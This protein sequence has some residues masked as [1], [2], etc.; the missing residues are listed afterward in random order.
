MGVR[1]RRRSGAA[2]L[3]ALATLCAILFLTFLD[4]T[5]VSVTLANIQT[6]L[7]SGITQ[8][9]WIVDGY[10]L[11][12]AGLMLAGGTLG[13][14]FGRKKVMLAGVALF[15]GGWRVRARPA[16]RPPGRPS[17]GRR[18]GSGRSSAACW[19]PASAGAAS[20]GSTWASARWHSSPRG[21]RFLRTPIRRGDVWTFQDSRSAPRQ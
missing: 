11:A 3:P 19:S 8:L 7:H 17:R 13:D 6:S 14:L 18:W 4:N 10:L 15:C 9:Q 20:S 16:A 5:V 21:R 1:A 2:G 12:F